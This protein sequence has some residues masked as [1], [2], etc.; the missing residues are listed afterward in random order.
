[1]RFHPL[2]FTTLLT[3]LAPFM[4][5]TGWADGIVVDKIYHPYVDAM[6]QEL[7]WRAVYQDQQPEQHDNRQLHRFAYGRAFGER[8]F[9]EIYLV[10]EK[11]SEQSFDLEAMELEARTQLTEQGEYWADWGLLFELEKEF[12]RDI[13]EAG[14]GIIAEKEI[15]PWS[16]TANL[17]ASQEWGQDISDELESTLGI[18]SRYRLSRSFEPGLEFHS[19]QDTKAFGPIIMGNIP[20][21]VRRSV[22]WELGWLLGLEGDSPD[23]SIRAGIEYEF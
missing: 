8:W 11:S 6:E 22:H 4:S 1:M 21:G 15:G 3:A 5:I 14:I 9:G 10:G 16:V 13:W 12:G 23:N 20:T 19:G 18:Q 2:F 17:I 7:E